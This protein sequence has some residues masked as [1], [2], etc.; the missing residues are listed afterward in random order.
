[1]RQCF[2]WMPFIRLNQQKL[3]TIGFEKVIETTRSRTRRNLIWASSL[4]RIQPELKSNRAALESDDEHVRGNMLNPTKA[5]TSAIKDYFN[6]KLSKG[7]GS[8]TYRI[9]DNFQLLES[10]PSSLMGMIYIPI[11]SIFNFKFKL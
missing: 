3:A 5:S 1:M 10:A 8:L 11:I 4:T 2:S 7:S 9:T 6:V